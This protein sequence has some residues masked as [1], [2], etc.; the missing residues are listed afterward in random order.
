[1]YHCHVKPTKDDLN[2]AN[3]ALKNVDIAA[4]KRNAVSAFAS[5]KR[6]FFNDLIDQVQY[7]QPNSTAV[8][9]SNIKISGNDVITRWFKYCSSVDQTLIGIRRIAAIKAKCK[10]PAI[11]SSGG[12]RL[13]S[14]RHCLF[15]PFVMIK[16][17]KSRHSHNEIK[18]RMIEAKRQQSISAQKK[19]QVQIDADARFELN[20]AENN[21]QL[22]KLQEVISGDNTND[23]GSIVHNQAV[24]DEYCE[25]DSDSDNDM[26]M[27][28]NERQSD[29]E[30]NYDT[31]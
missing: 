19:E 15:Q 4:S 16:R 31:F 20:I 22:N 3:S 10:L 14:D 18:E 7:F 5:L 28:I 25:I 21:V 30:D 24:V 1:M 27:D 12:M 17:S 23:D 26:N 29:D 6:V 11:R 2:K 8:A 13:P 9:Q